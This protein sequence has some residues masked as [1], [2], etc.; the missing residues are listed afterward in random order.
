MLIDSDITLPFECFEKYTKFNSIRYFR[1]LNISIKF[2]AV[3]TT[4]P[5]IND[6]LMQY[7]LFMVSICCRYFY[8]N[9]NLLPLL[10]TWATCIHSGPA[11]GSE[12]ETQTV[13]GTSQ[14]TATDTAARLH[15]RAGTET[16][17]T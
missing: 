3:Q 6:S 16:S 7:F 5:L 2:K 14:R 13:G 15:C 11:W 10:Q 17:R 8:C 1:S 9:C 4:Y 12:A